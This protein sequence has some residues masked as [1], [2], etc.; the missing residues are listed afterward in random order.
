[1]GGGPWRG[2]KGLFTHGG[3]N[4]VVARGF[5]NALAGQRAFTASSHGWSEARVSLA[6]FAGQWLKVRFR[7]S[8]DRAVGDRG[9]YIDDVRVYSCAA[10][11][12][13]PT[14]T[15]T[16]DAGA[17]TTADAQV[18]V[19]LTYADASTWVTHLRVAGN[20]QLDGQGRLLQGIDM[21]IRDA[22]AWDLTRRERGR[23]GRA[24]SQGRLCAGA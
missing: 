1:M 19:T 24:W 10:D 8:S 17:P 22:L 11:G 4:G 15:L 14:G 18:G 7:M 5:G 16:I 13:R 9:W 2:V 20:A 3:Y 12:D 6:P 23:C 21:P